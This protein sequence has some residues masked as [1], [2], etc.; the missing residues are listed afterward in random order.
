MVVTPVKIQK[1]VKCLQEAEYDL[2]EIEFLQQGFTNGFDICYEGP[3]CRQSEA[4]NIPFT[5]GNQIELWNKLMKEVQLSR[6][7][8][9][10]RD[11]PF[12]NYIQSPIGL[13]PK[14]GGQK[15]KA[16]LPFIIQFQ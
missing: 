15:N 14:A 7:A 3:V 5:V 2:G 10:F 8:G 11:I 1:L 4:E 13:V 6:V 9:P 16:H 12:D